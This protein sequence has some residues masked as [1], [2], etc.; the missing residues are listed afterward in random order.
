MADKISE[1]PEKTVFNNDDLMDISSFQ[2]VGSYVSEKS[3]LLQ[4][5]DYIKNKVGIYGSDGTVGTN[6]VATLT[7]NITFIKDAVTAL[8]ISQTF[9]GVRT[10][11]KFSNENFRVVGSSRFGG[12]IQIEGTNSLL[13]N[14]SGFTSI[15]AVAN[16]VII[17]GNG[18]FNLHDGSKDFINTVSSGISGNNLK[19]HDNNNFE[20]KQ[21]GTSDDKEFARFG[22]NLLFADVKTDKVGIGTETPTE[23]LD[24]NGRQFLSNQTAPTTPTGGGTIFVESGALKYIGSSG[25]VTTLAVA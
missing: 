15:N 2:D 24:V 6:R 21:P 23:K 19:I 16:K 3:T 11:T 17:R 12:Y 18:G 13:F 20:F 10:S 14:G 22:A 1:Y 5:V 4:V 7:D 25:T 9:V 8:F